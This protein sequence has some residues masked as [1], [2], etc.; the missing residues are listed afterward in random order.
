MW[1]KI[2]QLNGNIIDDEKME[3]EQR[4]H[5]FKICII[6]NCQTESFNATIYHLATVIS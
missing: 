6:I 1:H 4:N 2:S 5:E 3:F